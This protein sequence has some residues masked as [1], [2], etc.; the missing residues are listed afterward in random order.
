MFNRQTRKTTNRKMAFMMI[1]EMSE[2]IIRWY[3]LKNSVTQK[4]KSLVVTAVIQ[5]NTIKDTICQDKYDNYY[6]LLTSQLF[7][8][9]AITA[10]PHPDAHQPT[11][12]T[13]L[14]YPMNVPPPMNNNFALLWLVSLTPPPDA[15]TLS[16]IWLAQM[17]ESSA[18][19]THV[20]PRRSLGFK[21]AH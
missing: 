2:Q 3:Q 9:Q 6:E 8:L 5:P 19:L 21:A 4:F 15:P 7:I 13:P 18:A 14:T 20:H 12:H 11:T 10:L 17:V 1:W 16:H